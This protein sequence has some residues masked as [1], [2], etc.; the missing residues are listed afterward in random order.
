MRLPSVTPLEENRLCRNRDE[1]DRLVKEAL[2]RGKGAFLKIF[3]KAGG[4]PYYATILIDDE[5]VLAVET[6]D[7]SSGAS[8]VG[9]GALDV[10]NKMVAEGPLVV[11]VYPLSDVDVKM[12]IVD[13]IDVYNNTP[14]MPLSRL[15]SSPRSEDTVGG[16]T[17]VQALSKPPEVVGHKTSVEKPRRR[18]EVKIKAPVELDPYLRGMAKRINSLAKASGIELSGLE[19]EA[20][21][22]RY[23]LGSGSAVHATVKLY[24]GG[25][26]TGNIKN[27]FESAI[28]RE[29]GELSKDL[30]KRVV[31][32]RVLFS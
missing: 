20:K 18:F 11:D 25:K 6:V 3:G 28:Y 17:G 23:A 4:R 7:V 24:T 9:S 19:I 1:F 13:N 10:V 31:I 22:V 32:S 12:S 21:E 29:A 5:K 15:H 16:P 2:A 27:D 14:K 8:L 30:G 26:V